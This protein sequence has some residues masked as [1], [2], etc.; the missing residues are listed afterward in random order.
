MSGLL[1]ERAVHVGARWALWGALSC[2]C[3]CPEVDCPGGSS[4]RESEAWFD[5]TSGAQKRVKLKQGPTLK[6]KTATMKGPPLPGDGAPAASTDDV[7]LA[8]VGKAGGFSAGLAEI[9]REDVGTFTAT[10]TLAVDSPLGLIDGASEARIDLYRPP[11]ADGEIFSVGVRWSQADNGLVAFARDESGEVGTPITFPGQWE[12]DVR[13][14]QTETDFTWSARAT[15]AVLAAAHAGSTLPA[16]IDAAGGALLGADGDPFQTLHTEALPVPETPFELALA[17]KSLD[18]GGAVFFD[19]LR[20][21]GPQIG[22][23]TERPLMDAIGEGALVPLQEA[24]G[25][26]GGGAPDFA[27]LALALEDVDAALDDVR[28][29]VAAAQ[30]DHTLQASTQAKRALGAL[31]KATA[32]GQKAVK[33]LQAGDVAK[34]EPMTAHVQ[35]AFDGAVVAVANLGGFKGGSLKQLPIVLL[36]PASEQPPP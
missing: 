23:V 28:A 10:A 31:K 21:E 16:W 11:T 25:E 22:G 19:F 18:P 20:L 33:L 29:D 15:P 12:V 6:L 3:A 26:L 4:P 1:L 27:A 30:K 8:F 5:A 35:A 32:R 9:D 2:L 14:V 13:L 34:L 36:P 7:R 24:L 17:C